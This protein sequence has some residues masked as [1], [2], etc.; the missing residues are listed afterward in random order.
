MEI[1]EA[2][3]SLASLVQP[4]RLQAFRHLVQH[5]PEGLP[6]GELARRLAVPPNTLSAHLNVLS[7]AGLTSA[8]RRGR[9]VYYRANVSRLA[10]LTTFLAQ[11]CCGG[12]GCADLPVITCTEPSA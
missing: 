7:H 11:D 12:G 2:I 10:A 3:V 5:E 9:S 1:E 4:T 6:A 8:R